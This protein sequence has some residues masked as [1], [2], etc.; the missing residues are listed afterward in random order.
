M[1]S[2]KISFVIFSSSFKNLKVA[3]VCRLELGGRGREGK[4]KLI[5][6][7]LFDCMKTNRGY[8][9]FVLHI[10]RFLQSMF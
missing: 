7:E 3:K 10:D 9:S 6:I 2:L 5:V 8:K 4:Q 1:I